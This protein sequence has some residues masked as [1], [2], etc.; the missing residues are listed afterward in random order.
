MTDSPQNTPQKRPGRPRKLNTVP[1][2]PGE[3]ADNSDDELVAESEITDVEIVRVD[4]D[5][6]SAFNPFDVQP[7]ITM[8]APKPVRQPTR[9]PKSVSAKSGPP[10]L[11]E[12]QD[13]IGRIVLRTLTDAYLQLALRDIDDQLTERERESI[14]LTREDLREMSAPIASLAHKSKL[15]RT[16]G[17]AIIAASG[18]IEAVVALV[19]WMRRVNRVTRK[20]RAN[21]PVKGQVSH[22]SYRA[23]DE[24]GP[25]DSGQPTGTYFGIVNPGSG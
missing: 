6:P 11:D 8:E 20:Y 13:F 21:K 3:T 23:N 22:E 12:W 1:P 15:G 9:E 17:R 5:A 25:V 14:R 16:K 7:E 24:Q 4:E 10:T 18:S 19:I 2:P